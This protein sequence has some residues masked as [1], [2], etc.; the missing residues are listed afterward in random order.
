MSK[1]MHSP[2]VLLLTG[3]HC[4][5]CPKVLASLQALLAEGAI[6]SLKA[7]NIEEN[8][9]LAAE[10]NIRTVPW[11]RIGPFELEGMR[12]TT[13][14]REWARRAG[15]GDGMAEWLDELLSNGNIGRVEKQLQQE[16]ATLGI[17]LTLFSKSGTGLNTRI[18]IS[19]IIEDLERTELLQSQSDRLAEL[20][21]HQDA[22]I[23][24]DACHF[25]SLTGLPQAK[26]LI[27]PLL[28]DP[29]PDVRRIAMESLQDFQQSI[30][31]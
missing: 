18:G 15:S 28:N 9:V 27:E 31:H 5:W 8:P 21:Y 11:V 7:V 23:R 30:L 1:Q 17:L 6:A 4:P 2:D 10:L 20:L 25:L 29:E 26:A 13:E 3:T 16:P 22:H 19:A 24:G 14:L 12:S